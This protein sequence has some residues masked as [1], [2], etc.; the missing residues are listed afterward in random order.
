MKKLRLLYLLPFLASCTP[1]DDFEQIL[2]N[3][4]SYWVTLPID[5]VNDSTFV[6]NYCDKFESDHLYEEYYINKDKKY[7]SVNDLN[8]F[9]KGLYTERNWFYYNKDSSL[10][11]S[12]NKYK[13]LRYTKDMIY[14][15]YKRSD[16][17]DLSDYF[18]TD[19]I[20]MYNINRYQEYTIK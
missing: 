18:N 8:H 14:L 9:E 10:S 20:V 19:T 1:S 3:E 12:S 4:K 17:I 11:I 16:D 7:L 2:C 6:I 15:L 5:K 13:L